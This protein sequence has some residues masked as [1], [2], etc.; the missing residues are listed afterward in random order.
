MKLWDAAARL[1]LSDDPIG[2]VSKD[3]GYLKEGKFASAFSKEVGCTPRR[4]RG[5]YCPGKVAKDH[6]RAVRR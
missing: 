1:I 6:P 3:A 2:E 5:E 4:F